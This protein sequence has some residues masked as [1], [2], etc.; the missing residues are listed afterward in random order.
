M[1]KEEK[2]LFVLSILITIAIILSSANAQ[3]TIGSGEAPAKTSLLQIKDQEAD[4]FNVT[5]KSGGFILPR[6]A[7]MDMYTLEPYAKPDNL[8]YQDLKRESVGML[9]YNITANDHFTPGVYFWDGE[10]WVSMISTNITEPGGPNKPDPPITNI[11]DPTMLEL[12]NSYILPQGATLIFPVMKCYA[13]WKQ[14]LNLEEYDLEGAIE[15]ELLWQSKQNLVKSIAL[16]GGDKGRDSYIKVETRDIDG[17]AT[18]AIKIDGQT[19][20]SWHL[21]V[22]NYDPSEESA[23]RTHNG[24]TMMDRNLG[25]LYSE[26]G[27]ILSGGLLYQ[28]GRKDPFPGTASLSLDNVER[29]IYDIHNNLVTILK[30]AAPASGDNRP[31]SVRHPITFLTSTTD[32]S[33]VGESGNHYW[34]NQGKKG[35][36]DPCPA[37]WRVP[38][39]ETVW[40]GLPTG[41]EYRDQ[42]G[43]YWD[44]NDIAG[45]FY[46]TAGYREAATGNLVISKNMG[47]SWTGYSPPNES[48]SA[49]ALYFAQWDFN[50]GKRVPKATATTVRCVKDE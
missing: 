14:V 3:V 19:M 26:G 15:V 45:G 44:R 20:W 16:D 36:V 27:N 5:S 31:Y 22:T 38:K 32:W 28:W 23:Q 8:D 43:L 40:A 48:A 24:Y 33:G 29:R 7:L 17:N 9:V 10:K 49:F 21:W 13:T 37:G 50:M 18:I 11:D 25:A 41:H 12:P 39:D 30:E 47:Y 35:F 42:M 2:Q 1:K 34:N 4:A 46:P 6:T